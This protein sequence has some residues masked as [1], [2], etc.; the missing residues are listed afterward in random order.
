MIP[1]I[2]KEL[3]NLLFSLPFMTLMVYDNGFINDINEPGEELTGYS[4][5]EV[6]GK[7]IFELF[8]EEEF[9]KL[10]DTA[11]KSGSISRRNAFLCKKDGSSIP[12][13]VSLA[14]LKD[15][16]N[17]PSFII[18]IGEDLR[19]N[20]ISKDQVIEYERLRLLYQL[21]SAI[22]HKI[23]EIFTTTT[24]YLELLQIQL[25]DKALN[26]YI[27]KI[28]KNILKGSQCLYYLPTISRISSKTIDVISKI[29]INEIIEEALEIIRPFVVEQASR[30]G[31]YIHFSKE[32]NPLESINGN[33]SELRRAFIG[34]LVNSIQIMLESGRISIRTY[35]KGKN[36]IAIIKTDTGIGF[37]RD[38]KNRIFEPF[39]PSRGI[40]TTGLEFSICSD[41]IKKHGGDISYQGDEQSGTAF[42]IS[43]PKNKQ[44][45]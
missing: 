33:P 41:I 34:I 5:K 1:S 40:N 21:S 38:I 3:S 4:K 43:L 15:Q 42:I 7:S 44:L 9:E 22:R 29:D 17:K 36:I 39:F 27:Q 11:I 26:E 19:K 45:L 13:R 10:F 8:R 18:F 12:I 37:S 20:K 28:E 14:Y 24:G 6:Q 35:E 32:L 16:D 25:H 31:V 2:S 23:R 30:E